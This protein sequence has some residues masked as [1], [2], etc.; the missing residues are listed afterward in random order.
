[1]SASTDRK[2]KPKPMWVK[3]GGRCGK[4]KDMSKSLMAKLYGAA[5]WTCLECRKAG[6]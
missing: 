2:A 6:K 5:A 4:K 3:C 1:M